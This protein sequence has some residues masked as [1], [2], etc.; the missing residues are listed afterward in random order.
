MEEGVQ[1]IACEWCVNKA[2]GPITGIDQTKSYY[3]LASKSCLWFTYNTYPPNGSLP[4]FIF[5]RAGQTTWQTSVNW[6]IK[7]LL[8]AAMSKTKYTQDLYNWKEN[9][10]ALFFFRESVKIFSSSSL[11]R[12]SIIT[13]WM[14]PVDVSK[15]KFREINCNIFIWVSLLGSQ[16]FTWSQQRLWRSNQCGICI[17]GF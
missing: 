9:F 13:I 10:I 15:K 4:W 3:F 5:L 12:I 1:Y 2:H 7:D 14:T 11:L 17:W 8:F 6:R 16:I